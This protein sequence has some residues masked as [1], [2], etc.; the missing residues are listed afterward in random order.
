RNSRVIDII[1]ELQEYGCAVEIA[2]PWASPEEVMHEYGMAMIAETGTI[3]EQRYSAIVAAVG[4]R[5]FAE[6]DPRKWLTLDGII[7]DV[8]GIYDRNIPN[9]RL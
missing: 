8:K 7:Y 2:D 6:I 1:K 3:E 9:G 5:E 4:H